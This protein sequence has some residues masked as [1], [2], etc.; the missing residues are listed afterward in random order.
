VERVKGW[1]KE[2]RDKGWR[3]GRDRAGRM[4]KRGKG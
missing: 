2:G 4:G 1:E 3:G